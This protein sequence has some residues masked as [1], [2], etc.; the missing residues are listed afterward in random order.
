MFKIHFNSVYN[1]VIFKV[2]IMRRQN[3]DLNTS[4]ALGYNLVTV[5]IK[6]VRNSLRVTQKKK[7]FSN[8][9]AWCCFWRLAVKNFDEKW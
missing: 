5:Y 9:L 4:V 7:Y 8:F 1:K 3:A 6:F 2:L